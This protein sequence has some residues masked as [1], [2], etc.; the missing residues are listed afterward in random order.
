MYVLVSNINFGRTSIQEPECE[1]DEREDRG[2]G[3]GASP[4]RPQ[5]P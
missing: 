1:V 2:G 5:H 4:L 3:A